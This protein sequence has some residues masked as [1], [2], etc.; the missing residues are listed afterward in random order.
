MSKEK[1]DNLFLVVWYGENYCGHQSKYTNC[2][3]EVA[4]ML[5]NSQL[6]ARAFHF[7]SLQEIQDIDHFINYKSA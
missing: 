5:G 6:L 7:P 4:K 3:I 2:P 1:I